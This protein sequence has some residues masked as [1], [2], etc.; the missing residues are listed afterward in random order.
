MDG[1]RTSV[2]PIARKLIRAL[3]LRAGPTRVV[4]YCVM[5]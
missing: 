1:L 3:G 2:H 5:R 4:N